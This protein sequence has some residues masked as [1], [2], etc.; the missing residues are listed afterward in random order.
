MK[1]LLIYGTAAVDSKVLAAVSLGGLQDLRYIK[2][3]HS[4]FMD[5]I[6]GTSTNNES[7]TGTSIWRLKC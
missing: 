5:R 4:V 3:L 2:L 7:W 1:T 6:L